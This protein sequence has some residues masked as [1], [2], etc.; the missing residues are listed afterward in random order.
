MSARASRV[1]SRECAT[2]RWIP[3]A[4]AGFFCSFGAWCGAARGF[5]SAAYLRGNGQPLRD[6]ILQLLCLEWATHDHDEID[7]RSPQRGC[8]AKCGADQAF[9][10]VAHDGVAYFSRYRDTKTS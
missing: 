3:L 10:A 4:S 5:G 8:L 6:D 1:P 9:R 7:V 2:R